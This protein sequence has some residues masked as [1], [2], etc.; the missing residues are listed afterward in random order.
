MDSRS[1]MIRV[2]E[3]PG[4]KNPG[5]GSF[6]PKKVKLFGKLQSFTCAQTQ[7]GR[8]GKRHGVP[9]KFELY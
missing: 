3:D 4:K 2:K 6:F 8:A 1:R 7:T 5:E 9:V